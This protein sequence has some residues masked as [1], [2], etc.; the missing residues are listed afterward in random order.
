MLDTSTNTRVRT[1]LSSS[2]KFWGKRLFLCLILREKKR[3][4]VN[5]REWPSRG[6][7]EKNVKIHNKIKTPDGLAFSTGEDWNPRFRSSMSR[8]VV[9]RRVTNYTSGLFGIS[10]DL[11]LAIYL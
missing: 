9:P 3:C 10:K 11:D 4:S 7:F 5:E 6:S 2:L 1:V 8:Q